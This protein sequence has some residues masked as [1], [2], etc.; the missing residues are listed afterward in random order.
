MKKATNQTKKKKLIRITIKRINEKTDRM[1]TQIEKQMQKKI[2]T[3]QR[4]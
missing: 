1:K 4:K 3:K 2:N